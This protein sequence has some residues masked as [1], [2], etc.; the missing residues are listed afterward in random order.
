LV[1]GEESDL[2]MHD[3]NVTHTREVSL[4]IA[5]YDTI[6]PPSPLCP[7]AQ[8]YGNIVPPSPLHPIAWCKSMKASI[9]L[10]EVWQ[11]ESGWF[12]IGV[13]AGLS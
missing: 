10:K 6:V 7:N 12:S 3:E 5:I 11:G 13:A 2:Y 1:I 9:D 4:V 8:C